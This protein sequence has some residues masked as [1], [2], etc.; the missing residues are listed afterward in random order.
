MRSPRYAVLAATTVLLASA[1]PALAA[2]FEL[3]FYL[4]VQEAPHSRVEGTDPGGVGDFSFLSKWD[5]RS[6]APPPY[7]GLRATWWRSDRLGFA[8]DYNHA[9]V[10]ASDATKA[11]NGFSTLEFTDGLNIITADVLY[12]WKG[13]GRWTPYVGA[14]LGISVPHVEVTTSGGRTFKYEYGGPAVALLAGVSYTMNDRW[15]LFGEYKGTYSQNDVDL[16]N[17][18]NLKTNVVTNALNLGISYN[19]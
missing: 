4:G 15:S 13:E 12:R 6:F 11:A 7:Y 10:Y 3:S 2:D 19:F 5:G 17:G 1:A 14:G 16:D 9:K 18:G 8:I